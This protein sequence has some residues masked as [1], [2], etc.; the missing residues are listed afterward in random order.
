M[1]TN[2]TQEAEKLIKSTIRLVAMC[3]EM[4]FFVIAISLHAA[5]TEAELQ[6]CCGGVIIKFTEMR[7]D[8]VQEIH[9]YSSGLGI[10][11]N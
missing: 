1:G 9:L 6:Y 7:Y 8:N 3:V 11:L 10:Y 5:E 2:L 4:D